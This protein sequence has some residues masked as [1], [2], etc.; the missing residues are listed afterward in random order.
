VAAELGADYVDVYGPTRDHPN[1]PGLFNARD[2]VHLAVAGNSFIALKLLEHFGGSEPAESG[3]KAS[4][5][6]PPEP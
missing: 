1:K 6:P 2:G 5:A 4:S 3:K